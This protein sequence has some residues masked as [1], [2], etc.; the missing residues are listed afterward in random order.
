[1]KEMMNNKNLCIIFVSN[2]LT[3]KGFCRMS[4][5]INLL[6]LLGM[7]LANLIRWAFAAI[8]VNINLHTMCQERFVTIVPIIRYLLLNFMNWGRK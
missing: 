8:R 7:R 6:T 1:M 4:C 3:V 2:L 5:G